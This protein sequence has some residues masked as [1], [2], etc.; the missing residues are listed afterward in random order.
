MKN[1][2]LVLGASPN[3]LRY[4]YRAVESLIS[5]GFPVVAIGRR[6]CVIGDVVIS[7]DLVDYQDIHTITLYM[8]AD[9]QDDYLDY[10]IGLRP[11]RIIF[12]PGAENFKL[13]KI[14]SD[15][16]I[17]TMHAC[18]LVMLSTGQY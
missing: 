17:K 10:L 1:K 14:A 9:N 12:N 2:T 18:T 7:N 13:E 15:L 6:R 8:N 4:S 16:G 11:E 5:R 3:P